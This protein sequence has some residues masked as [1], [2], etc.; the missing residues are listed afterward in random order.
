MLVSDIMSS[1]VHAC[2]SE[3][4]VSS[5]RNLMLRY[6]ISRVLVM[7]R[8]HI[9]GI[10][11]KKD[12]GYRLRRHDPAWRRRPLDNE[13]VSSMMTADIMSMSPDSGIRDAMMLML[14]HRIS[15]FPIVDQG[16]VLGIVT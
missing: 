4:T 9:C 15:G 13:P 14:T 7:D 6:H 10:I 1:P 5:V 11:T 12:I 2:R 3:D 8:E 16:M